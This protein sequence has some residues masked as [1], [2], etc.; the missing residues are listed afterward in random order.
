MRDSS[1]KTLFV[2]GE[3]DSLL[4]SL[5]DGDVR[6][7][8]LNE[9]G[10]DAL[11]AEAYHRNPKSL[12]RDFVAAEVKQ[13]MLDL[14]IDAVPVLDARGSVCGVVAWRDVFAETESS[15]KLRTPMTL[16]VVIMAGGMGTRLDPFTRILPKPLIPIGDKPIIE[17]IMDAFLPYGVTMFYI[18][19]NH[20][21]RMIKSYFEEQSGPYR[22][23]YLEESRPL[24]TAGSLRLLGA[25][26]EESIIVTNCDILVESD[27][28]EIVRLHD[29]R[30]YDIT[31]VVS[32]RR[33]VI[34]YGVCEIENGGTLK[35]IREKPAHDML[36]NTGMYVLRRR[37]LDLLPN[38]TACDAT[39]LITLAQ[40]AGYRVGVFP[41]SEDAWIDIG[42]WEEYHRA[43]KRLQSRV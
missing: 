18:S 9:G 35:T 1:S 33:H 2:V 15:P 40:A 8:I 27:Y 3:H 38:D 10:L 28:S 13:L 20:K 32:C 6:R 31:I 43:T 14:I 37:V 5:S 16:P 22:I 36:V 4:G 19:V 26:P 34:P 21:A 29:E 41:I 17:M 42:Q 7:W 30:Q 24:G 39:E 23:A 25:F 12:Q 11:V